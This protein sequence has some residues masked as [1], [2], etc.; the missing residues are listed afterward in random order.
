MPRFWSYNPDTLVET[1]L[2]YL[3]EGNIK[4]RIPHEL[5]TDE[6]KKSY[7][8]KHT[9]NPFR[10][11]TEE[12]MEEYSNKSSQRQKG[13]V[14]YTNGIINKYLFQGEDIP[15]GYWKGCTFEKTELYLA[16][17]FGRKQGSKNKWRK[18]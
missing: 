6:R 3:P 11:K 14:C 2:H 17:R 4:G 1:Y 8:E 10:N 9:F 7:A 13:K 16:T 18:Q 15:D 12:W 5:W